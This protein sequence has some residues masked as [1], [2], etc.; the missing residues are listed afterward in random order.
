MAESALIHTT[1]SQI[2]FAKAFN[3]T[4]LWLA[5]RK[6]S[7]RGKET[8]CTVLLSSGCRGKKSSA[9]ISDVS[10]CWK[11]TTGCRCDARRELVGNCDEFVGSSE[12]L[13]NL[14]QHLFLVHLRNSFSSW[15]EKWWSPQVLR[16]NIIGDRGGKWREPVSRLIN[17]SSAGTNQRHRHSFFVSHLHWRCAAEP[18]WVTLLPQNIAF[19]TKWNGVEVLLLNARKIIVQIYRKHDKKIQ[20]KSKIM[21]RSLTW[22]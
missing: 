3:F 4:V 13:W 15:C 5:V 11:E 8:I 1:V 7:L 10:Q 2:S 16:I 12:N 22:H 19:K 20:H 18:F 6:H 17:G 14:L 21:I 9:L